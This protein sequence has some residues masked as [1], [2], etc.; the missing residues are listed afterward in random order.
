MADATNRLTQ[1]VLFPVCSSDLPSPYGRGWEDNDCTSLCSSLWEKQCLP[2][3]T[4]LSSTSQRCP[5]PHSALRDPDTPPR[6]YRHLPGAS[7]QRPHGQGHKSVPLFSVACP[8]PLIQ[9]PLCVFSVLAHSLWQLFNKPICFP[10]TWGRSGGCWR[11]VRLSWTMKPFPTQHSS[12][13]VQI[14]RGELEINPAIFFS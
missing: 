2:G 6:P 1:S 10:L 7:L 5:L 8:L 11:A 12:S 9:S 14:N 3:G 13:S 4:V